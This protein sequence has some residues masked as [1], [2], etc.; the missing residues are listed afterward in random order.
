MITTQNIQI[1]SQRFQT[2]Q[3]N[4]RREYLQ[5]LFLSYFYQQPGSLDILFKGGTALRI[6]FSSP[7]FSED[8][9]FSTQIYNTNTIENII[10]STLTEIERINIKASINESKE[11]SGGYFADINFQ[12]NNIEIPILLQFS[13][14]KSNDTQEIITISNDFIPPYIISMLNR[15][16]LF[17]EKI[18]ALLTR[19][20][21]RDFFDIYFLIRSNFISQTQKLLLQQVETKLESTKINFNFELKQFL[22]K[23]H[24]PTIKDFRHNLQT[25]LNKFSF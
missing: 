21:P 3:Q 25:E 13:K 18:Q 4:I 14:R 15:E 10:V 1:L 11:T 9:D 8:L 7:R 23:S 6:A 24:W 20:K 5:H 22:P 17:T 12:F 19:G 16:Q 2:T